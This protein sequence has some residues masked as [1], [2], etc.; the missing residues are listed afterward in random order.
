MIF[1]I[2]FTHFLM[3]KRK[4]LWQFH[5]IHHYPQQLSMLSNARSHPIDTAIG[6][7]VSTFVFAIVIS[8]ISPINISLSASPSSLGEV[9]GILAF[10]TFL[11]FL[12]HSKLPIGYG[13]MEY[14]FLSPR[15]H[16]AHHSRDIVGKILDKH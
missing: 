12:N 8:I 15:S 2:F 1:L 9:S 3:Y 14:I 6:F 10:P 5:Q 7:V 4:A 11:G 16:L 13:F